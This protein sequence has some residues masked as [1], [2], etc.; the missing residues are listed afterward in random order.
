VLQSRRQQLAVTCRSLDTISPLAT[1]DRGYA[2]VTRQQDG[3]V[4]QQASQVQAGEQ[5][6]ARLAEGR[7]LCTVEAALEAEDQATR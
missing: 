6:V 2:I 1:L 7:L 4:L 5:V 3:H